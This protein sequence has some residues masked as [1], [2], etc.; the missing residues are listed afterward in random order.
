MSL[1]IDAGLIAVAALAVL[2]ILMF[3]AKR[4]K[5]AHEIGPHRD[6]RGLRK[7]KPFFRRDVLERKVSSLFPTTEGSQVLALLDQDL[8]TTPAE[9]Q[10]QLQLALLKLSDGNL[11]ELRRLVDVV[12]GDDGF[13]KSLNIIGT[14][15]WPEAHRM[16]YDYLN[17]LPEEQ[18]PIFRRDLAQCL[19]WIKG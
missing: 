7:K 16:G 19:R 3:L 2:L 18:E 14:A 1:A 15:E 8:P 12:T 4:R 17:L 5:E 11:D 10:L 9:Q 6:S 13:S